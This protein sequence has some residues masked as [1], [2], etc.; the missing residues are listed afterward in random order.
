MLKLLSILIAIGFIY[1]TVPAFS[2][3]RDACMKNC[4]QEC[5]SVSSPGKCNS[6]CVVRRIVAVSGQG[7]RDQI[8]GPLY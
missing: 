2:E 6:L 3:T 8:R 1:T 7:N 4:Q 5:A